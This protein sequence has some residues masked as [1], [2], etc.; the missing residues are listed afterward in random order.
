MLFRSDEAL[1][2]GLVMDAVEMA[3]AAV[4]EFPT[5]W[6]LQNQLMYALFVACSDDGNV[7]AWEENQKKYDLEIIALGE[8]IMQYCPDEDLRLEAKARLAFHYCETGRKAQARSLIEALPDEEN[9]HERMLYWVLEGPE[10]LAFVQKRMIN[11]LELLTWSTRAWIG[12]GGAKTP[13]AKIAWREKLTQC[14]EII[15]GKDI[16]GWH[17]MLAKL[18]ADNAC[19]AMSLEQPEA[20]LEHL[21]KS[22]AHANAAFEDEPCHTADSRSLHHILLEDYFGR[23][24]FDPLRENKVFQA[25]LNPLEE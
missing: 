6:R 4:R 9:C 14:I 10:R 19:D 5:D 15:L 20:A 18:E 23:V 1:N 7:P 16:C 13:D 3:R 25:I 17:E 24:C 22:A 12:N 8:K 11:G 21:S 2:Q